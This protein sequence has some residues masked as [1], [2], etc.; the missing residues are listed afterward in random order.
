MI[1]KESYDRRVERT[2]AEEAAGA[3]PIADIPKRCP[4]CGETKTLADFNRDR[5]SSDGRFPYCRE[6][7]KA[8]DQ[9]KYWRDPQKQRMRR[10]D[11]RKADPERHRRQTADLYQKH[12]TVVR[13]K[14]KEKYWANAEKARTYAREYWRANSERLL[15]LERARYEADPARRRAYMAEW[16]QRN[17]THRRALERIHTARRRGLL[18]D[19]TVE[20]VDVNAI[21]ARDGLDCHICGKPVPRD[22]V[23]LDHLIP[24]SHGGPH[25][26]WNLSIAHRPCN[27]RRGAGRIPAQLHLL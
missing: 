25:V 24:L 10:D 1:G 12:R 17:I 26:A 13:E 3:T 15:A 27:S 9:E 6:C 20:K 7:G 19:Q 2:K 11:Y 21:I 16:R 5:S 14:A 4:R 18:R 23:S 22:K 8:I